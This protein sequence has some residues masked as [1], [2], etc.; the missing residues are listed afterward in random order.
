MTYK[1]A[2]ITTAFA[3][4]FVFALGFKP[5][6]VQ[7][8]SILAPADSGSSS[9]TTNRRASPTQDP[10]AGTYGGVISA[11]PQQRNNPYEAPPADN[12][13]DFVQNGGDQTPSSLEDGRRRAQ[14][15]RQA[16]AREQQKRNMERTQQ[17]RAQWTKAREEAEAK[18]KALM[19]EARRN[20]ALPY[21][22]G[23]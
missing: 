7:A 2:F 20:G 10:A 19:E 5:A 21:R 8:Q 4:A 1:P 6:P 11:P 12:L 13:Y 15:I 9:Y 23:Q 17:Q 3:A 16:R 22:S 18:Q 14:E